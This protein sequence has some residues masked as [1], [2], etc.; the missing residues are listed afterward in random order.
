MSK[1]SYKQRGE[2]SPNPTA[3]RLFG[4]M[5]EKQTNLCV[6]VDVTTKQ[7]LLD[8]A[9]AVGPAVCVLKTRTDTVDDFD[10]DLVIHLQRL[11]EKYNFL[12]FED[13]TFADIGIAVKHQYQDGIYH[14]ADWADIINAHPIV[15]PGVIEGLKE[16][17]LHKGRGLLLLAQMTSKDNLIS[18]EYTAE[19][20]RMAGDHADFAIGFISNGNVSDNPQ[21]IHFTPG[22]HINR[23]GDRLGQQYQ[24]PEEA[25]R[26]GA[27]IIIVG[28][29]ITKSHNPEAAAKHYQDIAWEA[30]M[31]L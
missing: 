14:I 18:S 24:S 5:E 10:E 2:L 19:A 29:G 16:V 13:H 3:K 26:Q 9:E 20:V 30:A 7:E 17:G 27:D 15:G 21:F 22:V 31:H 6:A 12:L 8:L 1:L 25:I 11:S 23:E 4:V 28:R